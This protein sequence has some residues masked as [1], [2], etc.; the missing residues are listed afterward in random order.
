MTT[1]RRLLRA[2]LSAPLLLVANRTAI[3]GAQSPPQCSP[4]TQ[5]ILYET[6]VAGMQHHKPYRRGLMKTIV[7]GADVVLKREPDNEF[8]HRAIAVYLQNGLRLGYLP[9]WINHIPS[10]LL[11]AGHEVLCT[12]TKFNSDD[13]PWHMVKVAILLKAFPSPPKCE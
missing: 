5:T 6:Y 7:V 10:R 1:R 3:A 11:D 8:D 4:S 9:K 13:D 2:L 12:I